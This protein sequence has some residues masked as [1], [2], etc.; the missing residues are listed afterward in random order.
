M[1]KHQ[2][3]CTPA[4]LADF[5]DVRVRVVRTIVLQGPASDILKQLHTDAAFLQPDG[6]TLRIASDRATMAETERTLE[7]L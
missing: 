3:A 4:L 2:R 5:K 7:V 1:E 6:T